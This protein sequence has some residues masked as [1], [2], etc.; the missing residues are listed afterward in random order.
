[1]T[2]FPGSEVGLALVLLAQLSAGHSMVSNVNYQ[3]ISIE[4][5]TWIDLVVYTLNG[6]DY[7]MTCFSL[8]FLQSTTL[9]S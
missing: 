6:L 1:M 2:M 7:Q 5:S 3:Q 9:S 4:A 8:P